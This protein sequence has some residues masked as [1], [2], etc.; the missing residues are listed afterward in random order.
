MSNETP[1]DAMKSMDLN[2]L[3]RFDFGFDRLKEVLKHLLKHTSQ[4]AL[5]LQSVN[6]QMLTK[7]HLD[8]HKSTLEQYTEQ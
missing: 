6:K 8:D 4:Q 5:Q 2:S 1:P 3:L 7:F